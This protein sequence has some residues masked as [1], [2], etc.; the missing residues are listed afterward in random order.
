MKFMDGAMGTI[1]QAKGLDTL[2]EIWNITQPKTIQSIHEQYVAAGCDIL[3]TNTFGANRL[4]LVSLGYSPKAV[5]TQGV[6][7]AKNAIGDKPVQVALDIGPTGQLLAP[8]GTLAFEE[9]IDIFAEMVQAGANADLILIET[10]SDTYEIKAAM[11]A[12]KENSHL[13]IMVTISPDQTG[14]LL[15][16]ADLLTAATLI[17]SLGA[18]AIGLNCG[19]GPLE[20]MDFVKTL[21]QHVSIPIIFNP[22]A[23]LPRESNGQTVFDLSPQAYA[24]HMVEVAQVGGSIFGGCCGTTPEHIQA[25]VAALKAVTPKVAQPTPTTRISSYGQTVVLGQDVAVIGERINPTGKPRLKQALKDNDMEYI[26]KQAL[27]QVAQGATLLDVNVGLPGIHEADM[28][29]RVVS[30]LQSIT[31]TPLVID[32][33]DPLAAEAALR[34]YNGKPLLNSVNG[35]GES[36]EAILPI[37][38]KYGAAVVALALDETI[39]ETAQGRIA[40]VEKIVQAAE[41]HGIPKHD[42]VVDTLTMTIGTNTQSAHITLDA[43]AHV[44]HT[45]G[46]CTVLGVSNISFGLPNREALNGGFLAMAACRGLSAAIVNPGN[47]SIMDTLAIHKVLMGQ[48]PDCGEYVKHFTPPSETCEPS[49]QPKTIDTPA[50]SHDLYS[51][52]LKGFGKNAKK[53]AQEALQTTPPMEIINTQLIPALD[54]IGQDFGNGKAFL[55]QLLMS[56][57]AA[58]LA[59]E[60]IRQHMEDHGGTAAKIGKVVLATVKGD[61]HDIGKNIVKT[62]LENYNYHVLDLGKDVEPTL[63]LE[64]VLAEN[65]TLVGLSALMTTTVA[66]MKNAI[67]LLRENAPACKIMVGG[68][69]LTE[70]YAKEIGADFYAPDAMGAVRIAQGVITS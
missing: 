53:L 1:L 47:Q 7:L 5:I 13:P 11:I 46:I 57:S 67:A 31:S 58:K 22:N 44:R 18:S 60:V 2:P 63:I 69:V 70:S 37:A 33:S 4:K 21:A 40:V 61:I 29:P 55:P 9:A 10:M 6:Q 41:K 50:L 24:A 3:K 17:E 27:S 51:T 30:A 64:T 25:M 32:T 15:T 54:Q 65:V 35:K 36:L 48:D 23:G 28:L 34:I 8:V 14:R 59:F 39:P 62:L 42:L 38:K 16:G 19:L 66:N 45:M 68:A 49:I 52:V 12:A 20:M 26:C 56:A 43:L